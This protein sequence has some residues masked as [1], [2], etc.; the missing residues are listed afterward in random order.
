M[1]SV[2]PLSKRQRASRWRS[3][4][5][6]L[7]R[8]KLVI[9]LLV[10][11]MVFAIGGGLWRH[12]WETEFLR[13]QGDRRYLREVPI[14]AHRGMVRD[15]NGEPLA[16]STPVDTVWA[17]PKILDRAPKKLVA[18]AEAIDLPVEQVRNNLEQHK[19]KGFTY[20][21]RRI[22]PDRSERLMEAV[23]ALEIEGIGMLRE[24]RR[25]YPSGELTAHLVGFTDIDDAGQEG[26]ELAY[27]ETLA[28]KPGARRVLKDGR[29]RLVDEDVEGVRPPKAGEDLVLSV[30][31]RLQFLAYRELKA[32][33]EK[34]K[35][36]GG[37]AVIL[38]ATTGEVLAMVNQPSYNPNG[39]RD[40]RKG[41]MR[42][43]AITDVMEPGS[44][45][46]PFVVAA[47][48]ERRVITP[49]TPISTSPGVMQVGKYQV[50]D[51]HNYGGLDVTGVI[52]KSSNI[53]VSKIAWM[54][55]TE[56]LWDTYRRLGFGQSTGSRFPAESSGVLPHFKG[57]S[58]FEHA[59]LSFG[60]GL[61]ASTLQLAGAYAVLAA[62]G[63][64]RPLSML[65][66]DQPP[67]GE[68]VFR[69]ETAR[70][71]RAMLE[72]VVSKIGTAK[73]AAVKGYRVGGK[74]GTAKKAVGGGYASR[75][76]QS[77]FAGMLPMSNP[78][79]VMAVMIDEPS[80]GVYYGG[81]VAAPVFAAVMT[82]AVRLLN[83]P[84]DQPEETPPVRLAGVETAR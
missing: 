57:W 76:Y 46:K 67:A 74:T 77:V 58:R 48:L 52:T 63:V 51:V 42:N 27:N 33:V 10:T 18:I 38:D 29:G 22:T 19:D 61:S 37:S 31:R 56:A 49:T 8:R 72:T 7:R 64:K 62:D 43:R 2:R 15:R 24:Y 66:L 80:G 82:E 84:P 78:R 44:T 79:L 35:A 32:A 83:I 23:E 16:V 60:Y 68:R 59:T 17:N 5:N 6:F 4:P 54:M 3:P 39:H 65:K 73:D 21:R 71:V 28:A 53:G 69:P 41:R 11:A 30:D 36:A 1:A 81:K 50:K 26:V 9:G 40:N 20:L 13:E 14:P 25:F 70:A 75:K 47:G 55:P 34:H 12:V 45:V